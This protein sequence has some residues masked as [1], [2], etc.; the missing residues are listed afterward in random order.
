MN[1]A[2]VRWMKRGEIS[3]DV[4]YDKIKYPQNSV[5]V[6]G[7]IGIGF[8]S[9]WIFVDQ[10][11]DEIEY[12]RLFEESEICKLYETLEGPVHFYFMQDG[13][14]AHSLKDGLP[15]ALISIL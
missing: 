7:A 14:P 3:D 4:F 2:S 8:K 9:K 12:R 15:M 11:V 6:F 1:H 13:A 5:M 10:N